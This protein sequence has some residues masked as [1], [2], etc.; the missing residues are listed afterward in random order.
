MAPLA[1]LAVRIHRAIMKKLLC[2]CFFALLAMPLLAQE[3]VLTGLYQGRNLFVQNPLAAN[4]TDYCTKQVLVNNQVVLNNPKASAFAIDLSFLPMDSPVVIRIKHGANCQPKIINPQ[5]VRTASDFSFIYAVADR[6]SVRWSTRGERNEG[7]YTVE[8][9]NKTGEW[10][11]LTSVKGKAQIENNQYSLPAQHFPGLN[12]YRL[13][14]LMQTGAT[15]YSNEF[16]Y[17]SK[18]EPITFYPQQAT[19]KLTLSRT[20]NYEVFNNNNQKVLSGAGR[21][22]DVRRLR[23]GVYYLVVEEQRYSFLKK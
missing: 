15:F 8:R 14:L 1:C 12:Q 16:E 2:L 11:A 21:T 17:F 22:I 13:K 4:G 9:L 23:P 20:V 7:V 6:N 19:D 5:V 10:L 3:V 18:Q